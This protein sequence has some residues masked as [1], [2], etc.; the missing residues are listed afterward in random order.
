MTPPV[1][2]VAYIDEAGDDGL[3]PKS[4]NERKASEW[5]VIAAVLIKSNSEINVIPWAQSIIK[6][7]DQ[8]QMT[9]LHFRTLKV[10]S[11]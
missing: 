9:H 4:N 10:G 2:Y 1:G 11:G 7:I 5:M 3:K 8:H 6:K